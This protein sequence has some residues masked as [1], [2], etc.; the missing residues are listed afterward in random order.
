[1]F[2]WGTFVVAIFSVQSSRLRDMVYGFKNPTGIWKVCFRNN[3]FIRVF[4]IK[5]KRKSG[6]FADFTGAFEKISNFSV[7]ELTIP[8]KSDTIE[9]RDENG[10]ARDG[11]SNHSRRRK[12][13]IDGAVT[14]IILY[15]MYRRYRTEFKQMIGG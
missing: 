7:G 9:P 8:R 2:F 14:L 12:K 5:N 10:G 4:D 11:N 6:Y 13:R 1:M 3:R 15:E